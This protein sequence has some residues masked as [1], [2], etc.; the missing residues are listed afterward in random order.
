[1]K[2]VTLIIVLVT[3]SLSDFA[4]TTNDVLNLYQE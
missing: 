1:M 2:A 4:Q 3:L